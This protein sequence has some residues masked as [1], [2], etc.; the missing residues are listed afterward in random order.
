MPDDF[1]G[2]VEHSELMIPITA[3]VLNEALRQLRTWRDAD[4]DLTS[5]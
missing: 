3:W 5:R 4:F 2:E 1:M